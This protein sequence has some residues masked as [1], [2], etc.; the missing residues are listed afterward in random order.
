MDGYFVPSTDVPRGLLGYFKLFLSLF[1]FIWIRNCFVER[2]EKGIGLT[3][4][5]ALSR[6]IKLF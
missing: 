3:A 6:D 2:G 5:L 1:Y 4:K